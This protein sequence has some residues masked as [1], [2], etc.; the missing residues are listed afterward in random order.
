MKETCVILQLYAYYLSKYGMDAVKALGYGNRSRAISD[1][2]S[3]FDHDNN[4]LKLRRDEFDVIT[5]SH[6]KGWH[7]R[8]VAQS[9]QQLFD[10]YEQFSFDEL[11]A[12]AKEMLESHRDSLSEV[13]A[14]LPSDFTESELENMINYHD[15][16]ATQRIHTYHFAQNTSQLFAR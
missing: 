5:G 16:T 9:V 12:M 10:Y 13:P 8:P 11:T 1:I 6:R 7:N 3:V 4:Y 15:V 14:V 2:G